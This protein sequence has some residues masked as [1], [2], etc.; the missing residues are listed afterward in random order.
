MKHFLSMLGA[1]IVGA[2]ITMGVMWQ[3]MPISPP[4]STSV[5]SSRAQSVGYEHLNIK[6]S[7]ALPDFKTAAKRAMPSVV[8]ISAKASR[9][10]RSR[11]S[12]NPFYDFFGGSPFGNFGPQ[13]GTGS[14]V[15][16]T[17]DGYIITNN[18]VVE[19]ADNVTVRLNDNREFA[20]QII[21][22]NDKTDIAVLKIEGRNLPTL[23]IGDSDEAEVGEWVLAVGNPFDLASTV[24][25]GIIS[26]KARSINI[27]GGVK[28]S[29]ESFIQTDA[30]VNPG[31][32]GG[33]LVDDAG[34]LIGINTAIATRTGSYSGY[35]FAIPIN[36]VE[37]IVKDIIDY[38]SFQ[39]AYLGV[40]ISE[41]DSDYAKELG[42]E[43][44][45]GVVIEGLADGGS[46]SYAGLLP[47]DV[48]VSIDGR[49]VKSVPELQEIIGRA[50]AG[51]TIVVT[52]L[53]GKDGALDI[54]VRL[55]AAD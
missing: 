55:K 39:R 38:G 25:A 16:Y 46:A 11:D 13:E 44:V 47:K 36:L 51:E 27:L 30:A 17:E 15:I 19:F 23:A 40:E 22:R 53:R 7:A 10:Q 21:G 12:G 18:H 9:T 6:P 42:V 49:A 26:A 20:A 37:R 28:A 31:S 43:I 33:A 32:S 3:L 29:I 34:R 45:Q 4:V 8:H 35:S 50:K 1:G 52:V 48:I 41:L 54:P 14:G 2:V 24:T 5:I